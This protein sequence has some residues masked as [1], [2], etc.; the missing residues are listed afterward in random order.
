MSIQHDHA[1][2]SHEDAFLAK[3]GLLTLLGGF[4]L[5]ALGAFWE[6]ATAGALAFVSAVVLSTLLAAF[7]GN[8]KLSTLT[9]AVDILLLV[10]IGFN[11]LVYFGL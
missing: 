11:L 6:H 7:S 8:N 9:L 4:V 10:L 3:T 1:D 2:L 5:F